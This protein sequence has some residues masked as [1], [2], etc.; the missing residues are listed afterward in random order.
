VRLFFLLGFLYRVGVGLDNSYQQRVTMHAT[1]SDPPMPQARAATRAAQ[2]W[3]Q[4]QVARAKERKLKRWERLE[5]L[6]EEYRLREQ[7]RLSPPLV[8]AN[9]SSE[10]EE[11]ESDGGRAAP[12]RWNT[13]PLSPRAAKVTVEFI[14]AAGA[15]ASAPGSSVEAP[16]GAAEAPASA[17]EVPPTLEEEEV[18]FLQFEVSNIS[19][20]TPLISRG[21][22]SFF[23]FLAD[24]VTLI[25]PT[26]APAKAL[27]SGAPTTTWRRSAR[28]PRTTASAAATGESLRVRA[29]VTEP[30]QE[31][32]AA[33]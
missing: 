14:S 15:E 23:C 32:A 16:A 9:S 28:V 26:L 2:R 21:H 20:R 33:A 3:E 8:S 18:G 11:E 1:R 29:A 13:P 4:E 19:P 22:R 24:R 27:R 17:T 10:E 6:D 7:Q 25:V 30:Q 5:Q 31:G 12:E